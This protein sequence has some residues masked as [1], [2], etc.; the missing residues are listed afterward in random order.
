MLLVHGYLDQDQL[1]MHNVLLSFGQLPYSE[2]K[3]EN[4]KQAII[5]FISFSLI[6]G[7]RCKSSID[8][9]LYRMNV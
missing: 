9:Y 3:L 7:E 2:L 6:Y 4:L 1:A 5:G 8:T